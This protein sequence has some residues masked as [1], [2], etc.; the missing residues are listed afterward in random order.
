M[1]L[2]EDVKMAE[3]CGWDTFVSQ[4]Y[5]RPYCLQQQSG[6]YQRG[7]IRLSVPDED[8]EDCL[9][10]VPADR[11]Y[12]G[13]EPVKLSVW[14]ARNPDEPLDNQKWDTDLG[15]WWERHFFPSLQAVANDLH[16]RG[17]LEAGDYVINI[18]W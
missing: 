8:F 7:I 14:L 2:F 17:L 18:D 16:Q 4:V 13:D 3:S 15:I 6:C 10:E 12:H 5:G 9:D 11:N 1:A